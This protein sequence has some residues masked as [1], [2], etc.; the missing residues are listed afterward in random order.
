MASPRSLRKATSRRRKPSGLDITFWHSLAFI[1][2]GTITIYLIPA[3]PYCRYAM[4]LILWAVAYHYGGDREGYGYKRGLA[5]GRARCL[6]DV[7][8]G[9]YPLETEDDD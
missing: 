1:A 8:E 9:V 6:L 3:N 4:L 5:D 7:E 2:V